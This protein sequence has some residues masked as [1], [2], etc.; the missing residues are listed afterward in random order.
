MIVANLPLVFGADFLAGFKRAFGGAV[1]SVN[2][3]F[4][5]FFGYSVHVF[6]LVELMFLPALSPE[7]ARSVTRRALLW[8]FHR[9]VLRYTFGYLFRSAPSVRRKLAA[10]HSEPIF[11]TIPNRRLALGAELE[12]TRRHLIA[13]VKPGLNA[14]KEVR[15]GVFLRICFAAGRMHDCTAF[16]SVNVGNWLLGCVHVSS[17]NRAKP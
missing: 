16:Q 11:W 10:A 6:V 13:W 7:S 17:F 8:L 12:P 2:R 4:Q 3:G 14:G 1:D 9:F 15:L 5:V